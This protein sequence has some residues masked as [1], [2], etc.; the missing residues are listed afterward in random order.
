MACF[1]AKFPLSFYDL[2]FMF[3]ADLFFF[4]LH[5]TGWDPV[6]DFVR[7]QQTGIVWEAPKQKE[8]EYPMYCTMDG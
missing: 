1:A 3:L 2:F 6:W 5:S 4:F 8:L 7:L